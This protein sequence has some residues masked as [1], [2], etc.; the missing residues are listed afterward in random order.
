M[1][2]KKIIILVLA[3][4]MLSFG[5]IAQSTLPIIEQ[6]LAYHADVMINASD[7]KHRMKSADAFKDLL[8]STLNSDLSY[9][10]PFDSIKW[11]SKLEAEDHSFRIF[12]WIIEDNQKVSHPYGYIQLADGN[13]ITLSDN[14]VLTTDS[15]FEIT[16]ENTWYGAL[17]YHMMPFIHDGI[18]DYILFGYKQLG[19]F[20]KVKIL[21][22]LSIE[23]GQVSFGKELFVKEIEDARDEERTRLILTYSSDANVT[24]NY[25]AGMGMI[26]YDN[27]IARM[28]M[29]EGQGPTQLPDGSYVA[30]KPDSNRW[31]YVDK[32]FEQTQEFAPRPKPVLNGKRGSGLFDSSKKSKK[33]K[34]H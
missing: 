31:L 19:K 25:N 34:R 27:L 17:Y 2:I 7:A 12:S 8:V 3:G 32:L 16:D 21:E 4:W 5:L 24:L 28:G 22:V 6:D 33:K 11:I 18:T 1:D 26:V 13:L 30:Y 23:N 10:Y 14:A 15:E 20:D 29:L 9:A